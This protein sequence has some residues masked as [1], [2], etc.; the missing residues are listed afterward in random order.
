MTPLELGAAVALLTV[1][2][3][4]IGVPVAFALGGVAIAT[5]V[6]LEGPEGLNRVAD[7]FLWALEDV[8][9]LAV[10]LFVLMGVAASLTPAAGDLR[11]LLK[12]W[13]HKP[14]GGLIVAN[15]FA[16]ML[17][18][19]LSSTGTGTCLAVGREGLPELRERR[20]PDGIAAGAIA[21]G[22]TLGILIPPSLTMIVYGIATELS[23]GRLFLAGLLP[24]LFLTGLFAGWSLLAARRWRGRF[25]AFARG[26]SRGELWT[27][28]PKVLPFL[29][30]IAG[31]LYAL[32]TGIARPFEAAGVA[33]VAC[34]VL[35]A[36]IYGMW[37][38]AALWRVLRES[39]RE[40]AAVLM[41]IAAAALFGDMLAHFAVTEAV[42][43]AVFDLGLSRWQLMLAVNLYLLVAGLF[44]PAVAVILMSVPIL[45]P[46]VVN[47]GFDPYWFAALMTVNLQIG[48]ITPPMGLNL[49]AVRA[50]A[51]DIPVATVLKGALPFV[52]CMVLGMV[53]LY[54]YPEIAIWLPDRLMGPAP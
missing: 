43:R 19:G 41:V 1:V 44:L 8:T 30:V 53:A 27:I 26:Y 2:V 50:L 32:W 46:L 15:L 49:Y 6:W 5:L 25:G 37:R 51:P 34:V 48:L 21:A 47:A 22:G 11:E 29:A 28:A 12:R 3:L 38:P 54:L 9:L 14:A 52:A 42:E 35:A 16:S 31:V 17:F 13:L 36:A 7:S 39:T 45:V 20:Y 18:S 40:A 4:V 24:G 33:A 23:I 10:P